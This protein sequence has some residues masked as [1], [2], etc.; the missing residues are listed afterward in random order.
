[1]ENPVDILNQ[2]NKLITEIYFE[3]QRYFEKRY[4]ENSIILIEIGSFL[5]Y[6][7]LIMMS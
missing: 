3:L 2:K 1:L 4:G 6:M 5:R 7:R